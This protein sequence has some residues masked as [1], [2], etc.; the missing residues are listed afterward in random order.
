MDTLNYAQENEKNRDLGIIQ[1]F[2]I[3]ALGKVLG[4]DPEEIE[5]DTDI[6]EYGLESISL[7]EFADYINEEFDLSLN[8]IVMFDY[9]KI[10]DL[11]KYIIKQLQ[12]HMDSNIN[13][14]SIEDV[15]D[16]DISIL[17]S[18]KHY[19]DIKRLSTLLTEILAELLSIDIN[20]ID[21]D[22]DLRE[23]GL[24]SITLVEY[25]DTI[26]TKWTI[27]INPTLLYQ[28][29][30][31]K[32]ISMYLSEN[33]SAELD[34]YFNNTFKSIPNSSGKEINYSKE[35]L[36]D[37][38]LKDEHIK[39]SH[40]NKD[41][42]IIGVSGRFP[43]SS[44]P[45]ELWDNLV[46]GKDLITE[47]PSDRW[48]WKE[49]IGDPLGEEDKTNSK[50]GGF[51]KD[52]KSFDADFFKISPRE[53]E[54]MDPQQRILIEEVWNTIEDAGYK[55]SSISNTNTGVF[56]GVCNDDYSDL[57]IKNNLRMDAYT[58]TGSYFSII[59]NRISYILNIH[60]PSV[61]IDTACSSSLI[62]IHQAISAIQ[63]G[64]CSMAFA[65]GINI[66]SSPRQY[67][68]FSNAGMLSEDGRC[69]TFDKSANGYVRGEGVGVIFLKSLTQAIEDGDQI[70]G[71]IKGSAVNHGGYANTLT[72]P[73]PN[74]QTDL[75]IN[76]WEKA[77]ID[78]TTITY[79][80]T[81]GTG[82]KLGDPI[83]INGLKN[84]CHQLYKKWGNQLLINHIVD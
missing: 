53:A 18:S 13:T 47:I 77:Q 39:S 73:N 16:S 2:L 63:N 55:P 32:E 56:V 15:K 37:S 36:D 24:D 9:P 79:I 52:I 7:S 30:T 69:K 38:N 48:D 34:I 71:V 57:M 35:N 54:L 49:Y 21:I 20:E 4:V 44:T 60:G 31:I 17:T 25:T 59:P 19:D 84:A 80:E 76:A 33:H 67:I 70:Y 26:N 10:E 68:S 81:H 75:I 22:T 82:T 72:A 42:A 40:S 28:H 12:N 29:T 14:S 8:P 41:I 50:W 83:E 23:F 66:C 5:L 74:A 1:N 51:L 64:D 3:K 65:G 27:D 43:G 45:S 78:P 62:A 58:S 6:R 46:E 11:T 61:A